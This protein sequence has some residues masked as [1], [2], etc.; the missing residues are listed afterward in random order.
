V[1]R[2]A[3]GKGKKRV[4]E[5][6]GIEREREG[7]KAGKWGEKERLAPASQNLNISL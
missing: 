7:S 6:K 3:V 5:M 4:G 2:V 1:G